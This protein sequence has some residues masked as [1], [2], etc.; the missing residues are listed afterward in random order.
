MKYRLKDIC[1]KITSGGTPKSSNPS[2][3]GGHI[4]WLRTQEI[5][6]TDIVQTELHIT[7]EGLNNS[8]AKWIPANA[9]I[10]AMYGATAGKSA[11]SKIPLTTNQAC[12]NLIV[13][14]TKADFRYVYYQLKLNYEKISGLANGGA[15][16]N[17][18]ARII[19]DY[20]IYLPS[21][22]TQHAIA[23]TLS[24]LDIKISNNTAINH[25]LAA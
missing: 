8:S 13:D 5:N 6:F 12:C 21:L 3:Y 14:D 2:Y 18:S 10:V 25:H 4:P 20:E 19:S 11:I 15:Q 16:Q 17:L 22:P 23:D 1:T 24:A 9:V 7:E